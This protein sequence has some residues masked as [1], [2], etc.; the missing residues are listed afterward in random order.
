MLESLL[1]R[2]DQDGADNPPLSVLRHGRLGALIACFAIRR[3]DCVD[4][5]G[6]TRKETREDSCATRRASIV[7]TEILPETIMPQRC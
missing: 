4:R 6:E 3:R 5:R 2:Q 7:A 1:R